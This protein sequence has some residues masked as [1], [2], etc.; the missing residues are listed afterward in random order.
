MND[1]ID[2]NLD[3]E[4]APAPP[5]DDLHRVAALAERGRI[6]EALVVER[7]AALKEA[8]DAYRNTVERE[9]PEAMVACGMSEFK[10]LDGTKVGI[11][12]KFIGGKLLDPVA[13]DWVEE[14][15]GGPLIKTLITLELPANELPTARAVLNDLRNHPAANRFVRLEL[16]RSVHQSTIGAFAKEL[17]EGRKNPPL[18]LLGVI[19]RVT[20]RL[21]ARRPRSVELKGLEKR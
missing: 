5:D 6:E 1:L 8:L 11:E 2:F 4:P 3:V 7:T 21:G 18:D 13:L 17:T 10:L 9:L 16:E 20:A 19:R 12:S 15:G 14:H